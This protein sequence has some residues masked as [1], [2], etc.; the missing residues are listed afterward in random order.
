V[1]E[2]FPPSTIMNTLAPPLIRRRRIWPWVLG[3]VITAPAYSF[4]GLDSET[5]SLRRQ[6]MQATGAEWDTKVQLSLGRVSFATLRGALS[7]ST[8]EEIAEARL[9]LKGIKRAS[10]GV[11]EL[12]GA[13][14]EWS[15]AELMHAADA[16]MQRHGWD[17][18]V[19]VMDGG[20]TVMIYVPAKT[21]EPREVCVA[22]ISKR[23]LVVVSA[24][25][26]PEALVQL[27]KRHTTRTSHAMFAALGR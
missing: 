17:R 14:K 24:G 25:L 8:K 4:V 13:A 9:A 18:V 3:A 12:R 7:F 16:V 11:Y 19:G 20:E 15:Q 10:V 6:L 1:F 2:I 21:T 22:V 26:D 27:A 5:A 23:E